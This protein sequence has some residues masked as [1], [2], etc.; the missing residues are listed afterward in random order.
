MAFV[1]AGHHGWDGAEMGALCLAVAAVV[2]TVI[3]SPRDRPDRVPRDTARGRRLPSPSR[4]PAAH[5]LHL[6]A[7]P[8]PQ[9]PLRR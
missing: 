7:R 1:N 6:A 8:L 5:R 3:A 4:L 9:F 2:G